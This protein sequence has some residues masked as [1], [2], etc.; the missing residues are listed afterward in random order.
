M[1][2]SYLLY[3]LSQP[4][5]FGLEAHYCGLHFVIS[6]GSALLN[7]PL[8]CPA[9][10][11]GSALPCSLCAVAADWLSCVS[12]MKTW[13]HATQSDIKVAGE[14]FEKASKS[15]VTWSVQAHKQKCCQSLC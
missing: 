4:A 15:L 7:A 6:L 13:I 12:F 1:V 9:L 11:S 3:V 10:F 8:F 5:W 2:S 14:K